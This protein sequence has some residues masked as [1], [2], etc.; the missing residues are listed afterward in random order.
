MSESNTT[1]QQAIDEQRRLLEKRLPVDFK[2]V[3]CLGD[4]ELLSVAPRE[5]RLRTHIADDALNPARL[6]PR[7]LAVHAVRRLE[8]SARLLT[9]AGLRDAERLH[10][11]PARRL[12]GGHGGHRRARAALGPH[13]HRERGHAHQPGRP[14]T[15]RGHD[16][17]VRHA[18]GEP[19]R[20]PGDSLAPSRS[21]PWW[22]GT[23]PSCQR[24]RRR[25]H[26]AEL[27]STRVTSAIASSTQR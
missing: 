13:D 4:M 21:S 23:G 2:E 3:R 24:T 5:I 25:S 26:A 1:S 14:P 11:L 22:L 18:L 6:C 7:R 17:D 9:R 20:Q 15:R 19:P 16:D 10:Q 8:W 27:V 12:A